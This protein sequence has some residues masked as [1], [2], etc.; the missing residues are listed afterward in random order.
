M[1][2]PEQRLVPQ[3][4][5]QKNGNWSLNEAA[6]VALGQPKRVVF[7]FDSEKRLV[8]FRGAE[9][10]EEHES[11]K[12]R[13]LNPRRESQKGNGGLLTGLAFCRHYGIPVGSLRRYMA[14]VDEEGRV[15]IG[16]VEEV[17]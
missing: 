8:A 17:T 1:R 4:S 14:S 12:V 9:P 7:L 11:Y 6:L 3:V 10:G 16:P 5:L 2:S 15:V 13:F